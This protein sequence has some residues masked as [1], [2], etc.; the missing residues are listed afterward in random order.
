[1]TKKMEANKVINGTFGSVW[2]A[3]EKLANCKSFEAKVSLEY[4][5]VLI[6]ESLSTHKKYMGWTGAGTILLHKVDSTMAKALADGIKSGNLEP[7]TIVAKL[8]DP[9]AYGAERVKLSGVCFDEL[10]L[11][12]FAN[13]EIQEEECPFTFD[14]FEFLDMIV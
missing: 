3:M 10:T 9:A 8:E 2:M 13:K 14:D 5:D 12:K 6:A 1:M 7:V 4:E 11:I